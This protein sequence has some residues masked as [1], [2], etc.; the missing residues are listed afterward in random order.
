M[1]ELGQAQGLWQLQIKC[2]FCFHHS[3]TWLVSST[4]WLVSQAVCQLGWA[5]WLIA[6]GCGAGRVFHRCNQV[7]FPMWAW[8]D[9][10]KGSKGEVWRN[11]PWGWQ[12]QPLPG[13]L[14]FPFLMASLRGLWHAHHVSDML[15]IMEAKVFLLWLEFDSYSKGAA[16]VQSGSEM[17]RA[18]HEVSIHGRK[19]KERRWIPQATDFLLWGTRSLITHILLCSSYC[20]SRLGPGRSLRPGLCSDVNAD[21]GRW[22]MPTGQCREEG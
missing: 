9:Q 15:L 14:H 2:C 17:L 6:N 3:T 4:H 5:T 19:E 7:M 10:L 8:L 1:T 18:F 13:S 11:S 12:L 16:V 20:R 22:L 21:G